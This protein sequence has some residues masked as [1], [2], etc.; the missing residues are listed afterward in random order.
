[1]TEE[2][3]PPAIGRRE[4]RRLERRRA[5]LAVAAASFLESGYAGTTMSGISAML[6]GSK[7]TLWNHF[8]SKEEL[9]AAFLDDVTAVFR[10]EMMT[11]LEPSRE[12]RSALETFARRFIEKISLP[13]SIKLYRLVVGES[14]RSPE[15]G[16]MFYERAPGSAEAIL[17][18]FMADH[19]AAGRVRAADPQRAARALMALCVGSGHQQM[20]SGGPEVDPATIPDEAIR[21]ADL[22][23]RLY[24]P[25]PA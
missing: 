13:Q 10:R 24:A 17:A 16:R 5:I 18:A 6:G 8:S 3:T 22:F 11:V 14:G 9:F 12:L 19:M 15:V 20:L 23:L 1:M 2:A 21:I 4:E 25:P 7:G